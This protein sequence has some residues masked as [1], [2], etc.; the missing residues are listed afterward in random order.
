MVFPDTPWSPQCGLYGN[1]FER[2]IQVA[3]L[4]RNLGNCRVAHPKSTT[5]VTKAIRGF[6]PSSLFFKIIDKTTCLE[7]GSTNVYM[8]Q[9]YHLAFEKYAQNVTWYRRSRLR[10]KTGL[11]SF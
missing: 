5:A 6:I 9:G 11:F 4:S 8:P 2:S 1:I 3:H 10:A 7:N